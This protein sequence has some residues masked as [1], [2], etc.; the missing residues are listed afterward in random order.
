M[1]INSYITNLAQAAIIKE[2]EK[3]SI[4]R[5]ISTLDARLKSHFQNQIS[6]QFIFGSY[7]RG[8]ILPRR[9]DSKSDIDYLIV[10]SNG[11][12][13]P[14]TYLNKLR[15]FVQKYYPASNI[16]QSNPTIVL[17]LNHIKFE[18]VPAI[19]S[20]FTG[21]QIPAKASDYAKWIE[22]DPTGFNEDL[23]RANQSNKNLIKPLIRL[24]KFW[25]A[26]NNYPLESYELEQTIVSHDFSF[27]G[28]FYDGL[29]K[30]YFYDFVEN[31]ELGWF[32][33]EWKKKAISRLKHLTNQAKSEDYLGNNHKSEQ[34]MRQILP[35]GNQNFLL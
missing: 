17:S 7:S 9:L 16:S 28:A 4:N 20:W 6:L 34:I 33:P 24:L 25:N 5:S 8:T 26:R 21:L 14:Q 31:I 3:N 12:L 2:Q 11:N 15:I 10:F 27:I 30:D 1:S 29:L 13:Q 35:S 32:S 19:N 18:L 23:I 22:T